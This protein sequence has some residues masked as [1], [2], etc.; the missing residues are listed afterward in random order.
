MMKIESGKTEWDGTGSETDKG[1]NS[2]DIED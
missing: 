2:K 1:D